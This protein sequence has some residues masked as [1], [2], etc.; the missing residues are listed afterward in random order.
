MRNYTQLMSVRTATASLV[1][2]LTVGVAGSLA[3]S[4]T[5]TPPPKPPPTTTTT[6]PPATSGT[7]Q[8]Q[9]PSGGA[10][11]TTAAANAALPA[12]FV[13]GPNDMLSVLVWRN[14]DFTGDV[15]V[16]PDGKITMS[17]INDVQAAGLTPEELAANL[18]KALAKYQEDPNVTVV[19]RQINSRFVYITGAVGH[20]GQFPMTD[21]MT[22]SNLISLAGGVSDFG[23]LDKIVVIRFEK[24]KSISIPINF[25]ELRQGKN[26]PKNN[27]EL[28]PGDQVIVP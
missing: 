9:A 5:Q 27:I 3:Q 4:Q 6:T 16:R 19:V 28:K 17:L 21:H 15:V 22:I 11:P 14:K 26:L 20:S 25:K 7:Q 13:I 23:K 8:P 12:G 10:Q 18:T 1:A 24:G 2:V